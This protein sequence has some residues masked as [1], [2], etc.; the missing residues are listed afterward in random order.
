MHDETAPDIETRA[1]VTM[2]LQRQVADIDLLGLGT[3]RSRGIPAKRISMSSS[4]SMATP[5]AAHF[6]A[7]QGVVRIKA[8]LRGKIESY[9][10]AGLPLRKQITIA[11]IRFARRTETRILAHGP[12][13]ASVKRRVNAPRIGVFARVARLMLVVPA[14][15]QGPQAY[16]TVLSSNPEAVTIFALN[17]LLCCAATMKKTRVKAGPCNPRTQ[18]AGRNQRTFRAFTKE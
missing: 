10:E 12:K 4:E 2:P 17:S 14:A 15:R 5:H 16:R 9:G 18:H 1:L 6:T 7:R 13:A 8:N 3:C 11:R